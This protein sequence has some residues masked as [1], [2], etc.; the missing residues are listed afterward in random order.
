MICTDSFESMIQSPDMLH[1]VAA[2]ARDLVLLFKTQIRAGSGNVL[3]NAISAAVKHGSYIQPKGHTASRKDG[4]LNDVL[5]VRLWDNAVGKQ[6]YLERCSQRF[7]TSV[8]DKHLIDRKV[9]YL[10]M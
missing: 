8:H 10:A 6:Q 3:R 4:S 2:L 7:S 5:L 1:R 9:D